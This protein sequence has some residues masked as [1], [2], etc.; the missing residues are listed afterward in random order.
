MDNTIIYLIGFPGTG[1]YSI[2]REI[3][4]L[5]GAK[6][7]DNHLINNPVFSVIEA[8]GVTPLPS[9]IWDRIGAI[10]SIVLGVIRDFSAPHFSFVFTNHL[11]DGDPLD[12]AAFTEIADLAARRRGKLIPVRL[13]CGEDELCRRI[14][15]ADRI[16][17]FK[18][19]DPD[20]AR[21]RF[22]TRRILS[23]DH[24]HRLDLDVTHLTAAQA[25]R[26]IVEYAKA[27]P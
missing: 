3:R 14:A 1:K 8:D 18:E 27:L 15:S 6:L 5:T 7:V 10:R 11:V 17:R 23:V 13:I 9:A 20:N 26:R 22:R 4:N 24:P 21:A 12:A 2:A 16:E 25:A 19:V